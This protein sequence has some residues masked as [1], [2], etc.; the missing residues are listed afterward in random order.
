M[1]RSISRAFA[2]ACRLCTGKCFLGWS[3]RFGGAKTELGAQLRLLRTSLLSFSLIVCILLSSLLCCSGP[4]RPEP[5]H[6]THMKADMPL[7]VSL[8]MSALSEPAGTF[9]LTLSAMPLMN[10]PLLTL[11]LILPD[12]LVVTSGVAHWEGA[13]AHGELKT[14]SLTMVVP[15]A[16][17]YEVRGM[18]TIAL[19]D[20]ARFVQAD[21]VIVSTSPS[22]P[23]SSPGRLKRGRHQERI[24]EFQGHTR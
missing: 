21:S 20:G 2:G 16:A 22:A 10:A 5:T 12:G 11:D 18:A 14:L 1:S 13:V 23:Q 15:D 17:H 7:E 24:L 8:S 6:P 9:T 4:L 19:S 3:D